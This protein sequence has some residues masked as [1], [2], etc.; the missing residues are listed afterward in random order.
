MDFDGFDE[1]NRNDFGES[2][3]GLRGD[4]DWKWIDGKNR[5]NSMGFLSGKHHSKL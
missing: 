2:G 1:K 3:R 4:V 5:M